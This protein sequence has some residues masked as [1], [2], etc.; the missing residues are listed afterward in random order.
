MAKHESSKQLELDISYGEKFTFLNPIYDKPCLNKLIKLFD[1]KSNG[2]PQYADHHFKQGQLYLKT[3][4]LKKAESKY[5]AAL[6]INPE[7]EDALF[8]LIQVYESEERWEEALFHAE[9]LLRLVRKN[10]LYH[11]TLGRVLL[12][13]DRPRE[14]V[15]SI[16]KARELDNRYMYQLY[17][18][19]HI[20]KRKKE[21]ELARECWVH[22]I[23][24]MPQVNKELVKLET[25]IQETA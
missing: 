15:R 11:L 22:T 8:S 17:L 6:K 3:R 14:A 9:K 4:D 18:M 12:K 5:L 20:M 10:A 16:V 7:Y 19:G 24:F 25:L 2:L 13:L 21:Y 23:G 1:G